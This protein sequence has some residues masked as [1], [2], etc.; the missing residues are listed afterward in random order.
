VADQ[1]PVA[2]FTTS[3]NSSNPLAIYADPAG[4]TDA[5]PT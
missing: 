2:A 5:A 1:P 4:S 3:V